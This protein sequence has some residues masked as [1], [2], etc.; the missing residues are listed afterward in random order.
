M[1]PTTGA[2]FVK[3]EDIVKGASITLTR[4][5]DWWAKDRKFYRYRFNADKIVYRVVRDQSKVWEL[6]RAGEIDFF[7][8]TSPQ[9]WYQKSEI[10]PVFDG[11]I[12]R[13]MFYNQF[14][15]PPYGL[16]L[17]TAK[18]LARRPQ[19]AARDRPRD[20]LGQGAR[21]DLLG[22]LLAPAG[23]RGRLRRPG[24]PGGAAAAVLGGGGAASISRWPGSPRRGRT[25][26]CASRTASGCRCR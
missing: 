15:R 18:P 13:Y 17:N 8:I 20:E 5:K 19:R 25:A 26:S 12:E 1:P 3:D 4:A 22:R 2:Y 21:R 10:P 7:M 14:P 16:Y 6:F 24:E 23:V 9:Y 11:Y